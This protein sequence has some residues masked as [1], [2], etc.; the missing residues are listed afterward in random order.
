MPDPA[1]VWQ[2]VNM[3]EQAIQTGS[4]GTI[5]TS[6]ARSQDH[7]LCFLPQRRLHGAPLE[8]LPSRTQVPPPWTNSRGDDIFSF[9]PAPFLLFSFS[10]LLFWIRWHLLLSPPA[11]SFS[12]SPSS[13][14]ESHSW[15]NYSMNSTC[16]NMHKH[17]KIIT[18]M[19]FV[20]SGPLSFS[21]KAWT[22]RYQYPF[23]FV[24][25]RMSNFK[26][27]Q[28]LPLLTTLRGQIFSCLEC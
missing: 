13:Y 11:S 2:G 23:P 15:E 14:S 24:S 9:L 21:C 27:I 19:N 17:R 28:L 18:E 10:F 12:P 3:E 7:S 5:V 26:C 20:L 16:K 6:V 22:R 1:K 4:N 8:W 25:S